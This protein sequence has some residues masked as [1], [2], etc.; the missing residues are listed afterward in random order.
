VSDSVWFCQHLSD[1][2]HFFLADMSPGLPK[3][4]ARLSLNQDAKKYFEKVNTKSIRRKDMCFCK[5]NTIRNFDFNKTCEMIN[6][7]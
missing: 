2:V 3:F 5:G 6:Q 1:F 4:T 7:G